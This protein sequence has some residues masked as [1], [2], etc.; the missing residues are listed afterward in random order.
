MEL[1]KEKKNKNKLI[2]S[3]NRLA[4]A[5]GRVGV[6][7]MGEGVKRYRLPLIKEISPSDV[8]SS[9]MTIVNNTVCVFES[10]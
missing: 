2:D 6:G 8:L 4:V 10:R 3:E 1:K 7:E 9:L 5:R